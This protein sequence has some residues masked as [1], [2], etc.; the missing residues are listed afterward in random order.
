MK[1]R[2]DD[3]ETEESFS[4]ARKKSRKPS[5]AAVSRVH[6]DPPTGYRKHV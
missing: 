6:S 2:G 1:Q 3:D 4:E 5:Q